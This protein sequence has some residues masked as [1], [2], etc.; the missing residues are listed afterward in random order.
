MSTDFS[1]S[2]LQARL[3]DLEQSVYGKLG[4]LTSIP[5]KSLPH[6]STHSQS[7]HRALGNPAPL[8]LLGFGAASFLSGILKISPSDTAPLDGL[9]A[10]VA[11]F[12]GGMCQLL[13]AVFSLLNNHSHAAT[14][15]SVY[16]FHWVSVG[17][18]QIVQ[19]LADTS[20]LFAASITT[21]VT[22]NLV[23]VVITIILWV[24]TFRMNLIVNATFVAL[25]LVFALDIPATYGS[26]GS[27]IASGIC[28]CLAGAL[29][30]Y[31]ALLDLVNETWRKPVLPLFPHKEH[32]QDYN[33][34]D[35]MFQYVPKRAYHKS[36]LS[37]IHL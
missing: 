7:S 11:V 9:F 35:G 36:A 5:F 24:P 28:Q 13:A 4:G 27:Q 8:G 3:A 21:A 22:Y 33:N 12:L 15:F 37:S 32:E 34:G 18:V 31:A 25:A 30:L 14:A 29:G 10:A 17:F 20:F 19:S 23:F 6:P 16:G 2:S 1:T 26:R